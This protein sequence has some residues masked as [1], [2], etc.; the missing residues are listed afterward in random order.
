MNEFLL[1]AVALQSTGKVEE[2]KEQPKTVF[3]CI[4][5]DL[6]LGF[7]RWLGLEEFLNENGIT[8]TAVCRVSEYTVRDEPFNVVRYYLQIE[9]DTHAIFF[10]LHW[11]H[12]LAEVVDAK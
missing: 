8:A 3:E 2:T 10:K 12:I 6:A 11:C 9:N 5:L 4:H 7:R 1:L